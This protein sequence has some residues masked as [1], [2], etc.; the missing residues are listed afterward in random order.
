MRKGR[1]IGEIKW[2]KQGDVTVSLRCLFASS[3][4]PVAGDISCYPDFLPMSKLRQ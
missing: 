4:V 2:R 1:Q 3:Q